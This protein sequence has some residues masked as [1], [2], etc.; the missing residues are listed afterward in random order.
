M[1]ICKSANEI[2]LMREA[3]RIV[4]KVFLKIEEIIKPG[5]TTGYIDKIA[6]EVITGEKAVPA[7]KGYVGKVG[8]KPF[9]NSVCI[10]IDEQVVHGIPGR[11]VIKDGELVSIDIG[12]KINGFYGDATRTYKVGNVSKIAE[13]LWNATKEALDKSIELCVVGNRL[14]DISNVIENRA[15]IDGFSVVKDFVGHGIGREMHEDP[16]ILN[17]GPPG[18]GP[19]LK[20]GMVLAIEPMFNQGSSDVEILSDLWTVV[21]RDRKLSCHFEDTVAVLENGPSILTRI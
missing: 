15:I 9:P 12:V 7:F 3:G 11:R 2:R 21:T 6:E 18:Q 10:S 20:Q 1:I 5:I 16:Q 13:R 8:K 17:Y 19:V 4:A 14:S